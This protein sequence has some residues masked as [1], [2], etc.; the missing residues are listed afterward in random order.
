MSYLLLGMIFTSCQI[1]GLPSSSS[2]ASSS[3]KNAASASPAAINGPIVLPSSVD[4]STLPAFPP[5]G[6]QGG[7][8]NCDYWAVVYYALSHETCLVN[9]CNNKLPNTKTIFSAMW[10]YS[11]L[12][13]GGSDSYSVMANILPF[14]Q[15]VGALPTS[16]PMDIGGSPGT[17]TPFKWNISPS[18]WQSAIYNRLGSSQTFKL[19]SSASADLDPVKQILA[20]GHVL[21]FSTDFLSWHTKK[22]SSNPAAASNPYAG[23]EAATYMDSANLGGHGLTIVGY[24][25]RVWIDINGNGIV[26]A[27]ELGALK[28]ANQWSTTYG[29]NG[30][31]WVA[32]D[33]LNAASTVSGT[34][35]NPARGGSIITGD[36]TLLIARLHYTPKLMAKFTLKSAARNS[37]NVSVGRVSTTSVTP[38]SYFDPIGFSKLLDMAIF[39]ADRGSFAFDGT[40]TAVD[41]T[42]Y[43]DLTDLLPST[44]GP[45][46]YDLNLTPTQGIPLTVKSYSIIEVASNATAPYVSNQDFTLPFTFSSGTLH[47]PI[48]FNYSSNLIPPT[49]VITVGSSSNAFEFS[50]TQSIDPDG[51]IISYTWNFG[52]GTPDTAGAI[53]NHI[54]SKTGNYTVSLKLVDSNGSHATAQYLATVSNI[55]T[56]TSP[57]QLTPGNQ[58]VALISSS[59]SGPSSSSVLTLESISPV[60]GGAGI[61]LY[62]SGN[63]FSTQTQVDLSGVNCPATLI[64]P[65]LIACIVPTG[66]SSPASVTVTNPGPSMATLASAFT[67][68]NSPTLTLISPTS[69]NSGTQIV[70]TGTHFAASNCPGGPSCPS[71]TLD[72]VDCP[73]LTGT[74]T[75]ITCI[76]PP[77]YPGPANLVLTNPDTQ[78][79]ALNNAFTYSSNSGVTRLGAGTQHACAIVKGDV[80]CWGANTS[81]Q[82]GTGTKTGPALLPTPVTGFG[83]GNN[84]IA[85]EGGSNFTCALLASSVTDSL[86]NTSNVTCW[87][88]NSS[89]QLG[90]GTLVAKLSPSTVVD[91]NGSAQA[92]AAG[93]NHACA[94]ISAT[95]NVKCWGNNEFGKVGAPGNPLYNAQ[96]VDAAKLFSTPSDL[97][98]SGYTAISAGSKATC[99]IKGG[100]VYCWGSSDSNQLGNVTT[101]V[102][103]FSEIPIAVTLL[104][105]TAT[106]TGIAT[107]GSSTCAI[108]RNATADSVE[109]WGYNFWGQ[110]GNCTTTNSVATTTTSSPAYPNNWIVPVY[111]SCSTT[112]TALTAGPGSITQISGIANN[113]CANVN[114]SPYCWGRSSTGQLGT[115]SNLRPVGNVLVDF[116]PFATPMLT[117]NETVTHIAMGNGFTCILI[118]G[119]IQCTGDNSTGQL[120]DNS[121]ISSSA[122][123]NTGFGF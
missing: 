56:F 87:G 86:N 9:G 41:E 40:T 79:V 7:W 104:N 48:T 34:I 68:T 117:S 80:L 70:I 16:T 28:I 108:V 118:N 26:D 93:D 43:M 101:V 102:S 99:G 103:S 100:K 74:A 52:D 82:L 21:S 116:F 37:F 17:S 11:L 32:Y 115:G 107:T 14:L 85:V 110:L 8:S 78:T 66:V 59:T 75:S 42:F 23:Q 71:V 29:N 15:N 3:S 1:K 92:I 51:T 120:G 44:A 109:C 65:F 76:A 96:N 54:Y 5:I 27:G 111:S 10:T 2:S 121:V 122:P 95:G 30:F 31:I 90:D 64:D 112:N 98:T 60:S 46:T 81:G 19:K 69:G 50:G 35:F 38:P 113:F 18:L 114:G 73:I 24:D 119:R 4:N 91:L 61:T 77:N 47:L 55:A 58:P 106:A 97:V 13:P 123:V 89:G 57:P 84:A 25:D 6:D 67:Y 49:A 22:I 83:K 63:N 94:I 12:A 88:D 39:A 33:A 45:A 72:G 53:V 62:L 105:S 20:N 36:P